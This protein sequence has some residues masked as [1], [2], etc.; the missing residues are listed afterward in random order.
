MQHKP[1]EQTHTHAHTH[2]RAR[3]H[4]HTHTQIN[5]CTP[6]NW[7]TFSHLLLISLSSI[8]SFFTL[9]S[10]PSLNFQPPLTFISVLLLFLIMFSLPSTPHFLFL[11]A[12]I[13]L[14][15]L[16]QINFHNFP[17]FIHSH[18]S[19]DIFFS[20]YFPNL[21]SFPF[22]M[23]FFLSVLEGSCLLQR[24]LNPCCKGCTT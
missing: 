10:C 6:W 7:D 1:L 18:I 23:S 15:F 20:S 4:T 3:T 12:S 14:Y 19:P 2:A 24:I 5:V 9:P 17:F 13:L 16:N 8:P 22:S 21:V 11:P